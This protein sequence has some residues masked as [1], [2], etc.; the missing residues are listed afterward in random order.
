MYVRFFRFPIV[1]YELAARETFFAIAIGLAAAGIGGFSALRRVIKMQPAVAMRP[2]VPRAFGRT[3]L[4]RIGLG[5]SVSPIGRLILRR[6]EASPVSTALSVLGISM[7]VAVLVLG[8]FMGDTIEFLIDAQ[9]GH[10]QRQDVMLTFN[11]TLSIQ[12]VHDVHHLPGVSRV[13]PF[14]AAPVRLRYGSKNYRLS[15][16]GLER[17]P[18]LY[19]VLDDHQ[20][21][22]HFDSHLGLTITTKLAEFLNVKIGDILEVEILERE[23]LV[24]SVQVAAIFSNYTDPAAYL[25]RNALHRLMRESERL[26]GAFITV[27]SNQ[28]DNLFLAIKE[29]PTIVG[30]LDNNSAKKHFR[31]LITENT[32]IMR[33]MISFFGSIIA[34]GVIYNAALITLSESGRDLAT[35]RVIGF[36]RREVSKVLLGEIMVLT[37]FA[38][39]VGLPI[40]VGFSYLATLALD[41]DS[42]RFPLVI[43]RNTFASAAATIFVAAAVSAFVV[44]RMLDRLDLLAVL[45]VKES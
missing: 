38:I 42:H 31:D 36:S 12:S 20:R 41:T 45:K 34:L 13:E 37:L 28:L 39:P 33:R 2:D 3:F 4:D 17:E 29:T 23:K 18:F 40:G 43:N 7:G 44:R 26:S 21:P 9:F 5:W 19:R 30:I 27:D 24:Q 1:V 16:M 25:E 35:L 6:L 32:R 15:L 8:S 14:R 22:I 10:A 11:E